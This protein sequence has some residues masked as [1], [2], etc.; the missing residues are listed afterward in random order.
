M[1]I[2][3]QKIKIIC[4]ILILFLYCC[5]GWAQTVGVLQHNLPVI[6]ILLVLYSISHIVSGLA[7]KCPIDWGL[8]WKTS[9]W[10]RILFWILL[11]YLIMSLFIDRLYAYNPI[12]VLILLGMLLGDEVND[13]KRA[14]R[15]KLDNYKSIEELIEARPEVTHMIRKEKL[16]EVAKIDD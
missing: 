15:Y 1:Y 14:I 2:K 6:P 7:S 12:V 10:L 11:I 3:R 9:A 16:P 4:D 5:L 13:Y 8:V